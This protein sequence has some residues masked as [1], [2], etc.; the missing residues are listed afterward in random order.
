MPVVRNSDGE[1]RGFPFY[2]MLTGGIRRGCKR[3]AR[4]ACASFTRRKK[5]DESHRSHAEDDSRGPDRFDK[6]ARLG[7]GIAPSET[8]AATRTRGGDNS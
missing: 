3:L 6:N 4:P 5:L 8:R 7:D 1:L 2:T